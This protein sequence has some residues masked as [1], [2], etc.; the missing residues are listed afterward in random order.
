MEAGERIL[1]LPGREARRRAYSDLLRGLDDGEALPAEL[2]A[3]IAR[4]LAVDDE[5]AGRQGEK[6]QVEWQVE[7]RRL[8]VLHTLRPVAAAGGAV[9]AVLPFVTAA[10][11][12]GIGALD[13]LA[14]FAAP[15][16]PLVGVALALVGAAI[17]ARLASGANSMEG[18][19]GLVVAPFV[20]GV[21]GLA[22]S[23]GLRLSAHTRSQSPPS[24]ER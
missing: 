1:A 22:V 23:V 7:R 24:P 20:A 17:T 12:G 16:W 21:A 3:R 8:V 5:P 10:W 13:A 18:L 6:R 2:E 19:A 14:R 9:G 4:S 15:G 11:R